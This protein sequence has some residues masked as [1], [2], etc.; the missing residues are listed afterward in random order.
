[1]SMLKEDIKRLG[2]APDRVIAEEIGSTVQ[3]VF[4]ERKSRHI[5]AFGKHSIVHYKKLT[6]EDY[7]ELISLLGLR[8]D[9]ILART[10]GVSREYVRQLRLKFNK[11]KFS[12]Q[13]SKN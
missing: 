4:T 3:A 5:P 11:P 9:S 8:R 13:I 7:E 10:Y 6:E 2:K 12:N 1:M